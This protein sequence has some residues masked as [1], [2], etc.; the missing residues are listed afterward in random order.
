MGK[1]IHREGLAGTRNH[2]KERAQWRGHVT[3]VV[4][5]QNRHVQ[6]PDDIP[7]IITPCLEALGVR[8]NVAWP[9]SKWLF[10]LQ[11]TR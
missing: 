6:R 5:G 7:L 4:I 3:P 9:V 1:L 10:R 8:F 2:Q 11:R